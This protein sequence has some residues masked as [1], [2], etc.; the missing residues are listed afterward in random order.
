MAA[1]FLETD[2]CTDAR[3]VVIVFEVVHLGWHY[4]APLRAGA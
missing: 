2:R 3:L 1:A 4:F